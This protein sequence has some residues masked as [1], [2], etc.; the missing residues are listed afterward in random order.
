MPCY[1]PVHH[2][3]RVQ[4]WG[5]RASRD[6]R[7]S[8]GTTRLSSLSVF[9]TRRPSHHTA[10]T[11]GSGAQAGALL[12]E[13]LR[14]PWSPCGARA[15]LEGAHGPPGASW[16]ASAVPSR[17]RERPRAPEKTAERALLRTSG[18]PGRDLARRP[19]SVGR[20][21]IGRQCRPVPRPEIARTIAG[22]NL[23]RSDLTAN[24]DRRPCFLHHR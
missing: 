7:Q 20:R 1:D 13:A 9:A 19:R 16:V 12:A 14:A 22:S 21:G 15:G 24:P 3:F 17:R 2:L 5:H 8:P 6:G 4:Q 23:H 10:A 11:T 18:R